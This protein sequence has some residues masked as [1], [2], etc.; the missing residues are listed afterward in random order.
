M[1]HSTSY[2]P[3]MRKELISLKKR[4]KRDFFPFFVKR[5]KVTK[6]CLFDLQKSLLSHFGGQKVTYESLL[7]LFTKKGKMS[8]FSLFLSETNYFLILGL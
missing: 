5:L 7:G 4:L 1:E 2:R 6:K 3:K 8:L